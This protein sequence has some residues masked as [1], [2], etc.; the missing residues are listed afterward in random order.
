MNFKDKNAIF[1]NKKFHSLKYILE[2]INVGDDIV[3]DNNSGRAV[4]FKDF[5]G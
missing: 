3:G 2:V 4:F 5:L 1:A